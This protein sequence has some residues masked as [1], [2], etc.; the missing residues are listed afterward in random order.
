MKCGLLGEKLGHSRSPEIHAGL[1]SYEY[2]LIEKTPEEV[3]SF[4]K[5]GDYDA[6]NVTIPYKRKA[7]SLCD[8]VSPIAKKLGNCNVVVKG[9]DGKL[10]GDNTDAYGFACL[11]EKTGVDVKGKKCVV[12]GSGGAATTAAVVL[13]EL[14]ADPVVNISRS[15]EDNYTNLSRHQD[16]A[17][18]VNGTP[19]GMFPKVDFAPVSMEAFPKAEAV[20]DL[21]YNPEETMLLADAKK[22]G[23]IAIGGWLMLVEQAKKASAYMN[24]N[25]YFY[26]APG[27]GKSTLGKKYAEKRGVEFIDLDEEIEKR[28]GTSIPTIFAEK[29]EKYFRDLEAA[30]LLDISKTGNKVVS[31]GGGTL[32]REENRRVAEATGRVIYI[33]ATKEDLVAR[34][35]ALEAARPLLKGGAKA[36]MEALLAARWDHYQSF[37]EKVTF[38]TMMEKL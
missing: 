15:G 30:T 6:I 34:A 24:A 2:K 4:L 28:E 3:E 22:R 21:I 12:L 10:F 20:I 14:G 35:A 17:L 16:A 18:V 23:K 29:G 19:V 38:K 26:G 8:A 9:L 5:N 25:L 36:K 32:L 1:G 7:F 33:D 13:R 37:T 11:V 27:S 31:L